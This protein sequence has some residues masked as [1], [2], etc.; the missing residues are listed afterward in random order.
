[1]CGSAIADATSAADGARR[2]SRSLSDAPRTSIPIAIEDD[3]EE[4]RRRVGSE[5][6]FQGDDALAPGL[7]DGPGR[8]SFE[9]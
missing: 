5:A 3:R 2:T 8:S 4:R 6:R 1:M 7:C 9:A